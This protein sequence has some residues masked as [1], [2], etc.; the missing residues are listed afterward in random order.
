MLRD[1]GEEL[2]RR[3]GA[4]AAPVEPQRRA[5]PFGERLRQQRQVEQ[6]FAGIVD[7]PDRD[8]SPGCR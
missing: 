3:L 1:E 5:R 8:A 6:P 2:G 7:D 4:H